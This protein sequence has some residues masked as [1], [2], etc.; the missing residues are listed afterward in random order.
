MDQLPSG[1]GH[2]CNFTGAAGGSFFYERG[3]EL[4]CPIL[5]PACHGLHRGP[6][7]AADRG[8]VVAVM[9]GGDGLFARSWRRPEDDLF[10][11]GRALLGERRRESESVLGWVDLSRVGIYLFVYHQ[12]HILTGRLSHC[13]RGDAEAAAHEASP[14]VQGAA[15]SGA[16]RLLSSQ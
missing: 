7:R 13:D 15:C 2:G 10:H 9:E 14:P 16:A 3:A 1:V 6:R 12:V 4:L 11:G 8:A 5:L